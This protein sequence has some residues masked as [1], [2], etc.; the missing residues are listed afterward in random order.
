L[1]SSK[2]NSNQ[3]GTIEILT[4]TRIVQQNQNAQI[5]ILEERQQSS[6]TKPKSVHEP[7]SESLQ[8][9]NLGDWTTSIVNTW[10]KL[11]DQ[12]KPFVD[13]NRSGEPQSM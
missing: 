3:Q 9:S 13:N 10:T 8:R 1:W 5:P 6:V 11:V 2:Y 12:S 7:V 4:K